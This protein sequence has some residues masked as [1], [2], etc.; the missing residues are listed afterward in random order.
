MGC[1]FHKDAKPN[2]LTEKD[3]KKIHETTLELI[4]HTG[5]HI[6][7]P[8]TLELLHGAG[9]DIFDKSRVKIPADVV[10]KAITQSPAEV[11]LYNR[12]GE[13]ALFLG[14]NNCHFGAHGDCIDVLDPATSARRRYTSQDGADIARVVDAL[15]N[16]EFVSVGGFAD[17]CNDPRGASPTVFGKMVLNTSKPLGAGSDDDEDVFGQI[18]EIGRIVAGGTEQLRSKPFFYSYCEPT[19]P[20]THTS[21]AIKRLIQSIESGIPVVYTSMPMAGATAPCSF[22]GT[23]MVANAECLTGMTIAQLFKPGAP[24]IYGGIPGIMDMKTMICSY[25]APEMSLMVMAMTEMAHFYEVPMFGTAGCTDAKHPDQQAAAEMAIQAYSSLLSG[26]NLIHDVGLTDHANLA[27]AELMVMFDEIV[28]MAR[29]ATQV[30]DMSDADV[31][32]NLLDEVGPGGNFLAQDHT[33]ENFRKL[34]TPTLMD[35]SRFNC[36]SQVEVPPFS[37][38]LNAKT[39]DLIANHQPEQLELDKEKEISKIVG[40]WLK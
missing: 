7:E 8:V 16:I 21:R 34:W 27:S 12:K 24:F 38:R 20:L 22:V 14:G 19:T 30:F 5:V 11:V 2:L 33:L 6:E 9:A 31:A 25:G 35:R 1:A 17:D 40:H 28:E 29:R 36:A 4:E 32:K 26:A 37:E 18:L 39:M 3:I 10:E 23:L 15:P 13:P